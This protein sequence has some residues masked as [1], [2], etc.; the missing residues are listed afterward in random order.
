MFSFYSNFL[1]LH[2]FSSSS[3]SKPNKR[4]SLSSNFQEIKKKK[5]NTSISL[6]WKYT[7]RL[8]FFFFFFWPSLQLVNHGSIVAEQFKSSTVLGS[9]WKVSLNLYGDEGMK[10]CMTSQKRIPTWNQIDSSKLDWLKESGSRTCVTN[11]SKEQGP[12]AFSCMPL[13]MSTFH[14]FLLMSKLF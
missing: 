10:E 4:S 7:L 3:P 1:V 13:L 11:S 5:K 8:D 6:E 14:A 9:V 12:H 2:Y